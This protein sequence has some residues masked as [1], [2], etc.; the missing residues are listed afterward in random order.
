MSTTT[1][2]STSSSSTSEDNDLFTWEDLMPIM[3]RARN[4]ASEFEE[5]SDLFTTVYRCSVI[6]NLTRLMKQ[7]FASLKTLRIA[8]D[9][10]YKNLDVQILHAD[11]SMNALLDKGLR[12]LLSTMVGHLLDFY[13]PKRKS[14]SGHIETSQADAQSPIRMCLTAGDDSRVIG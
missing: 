8:F 10:S 9:S 6:A 11:G 12:L 4:L 3:S 13:M 2:T 7:R 1:A 5:G 14:V